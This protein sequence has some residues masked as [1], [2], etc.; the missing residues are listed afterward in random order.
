MKSRGASPARRVSNERA[1]ISGSSLADMFGTR[2]I[3]LVPVPGAADKQC[4][5]PVCVFVSSGSGLSYH[6]VALGFVSGTSPSAHPAR[7]LVHSLYISHS[8]LA[9]TT[10]H[11][12]MRRQ[13]L[14]SQTRACL[15]VYSC[16]R[17]SV[18]LLRA[19]ATLRYSHNVVHHTSP[20]GCSCSRGYLW[21]ILRQDLPKMFSAFSAVKTVSLGVP[22]AAALRGVDEP[23]IQA[24][25][26]VYV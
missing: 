25:E 21:W 4:T 14:C 19:E 18:V 9:T 1:C 8:L 7:P 23:G 2:V 26:Q 12:H 10:Y 24:L 11:S 5:I 3:D 17:Q 6:G 16:W 20:H 15:S 13:C 22:S